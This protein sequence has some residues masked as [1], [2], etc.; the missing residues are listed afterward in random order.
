[1]FSTKNFLFQLFLMLVF[2]PTL[3]AADPPEPRMWDVKSAIAFALQ[4]N[5]DSQ[6]ATQR[7]AE[8]AAM[9]SKAQVAKYPQLALSSSY[10]WTNNPLYSFGNIV[11]QGAITPTTD[12][13][14]PGRNDNLKVTAD[15]SYRFYDGGRKGFYQQAAGYGIEASAQQRQA[16]LHQLGFEV[17]RSFERISETQSVYLARQSAL[18]ALNSSVAV[19]RARF[20]AGELLKIDLLN[21]EVQQ[22]QAEEN[23]IQAEQ[24]LELAKRIFAHLLGLKNQP[25]HIIATPELPP[26]PPHGF[27][28]KQRPERQSLSAA[29][30]AAEAQLEAAK[31]LRRPSVDGFGSY[32][33]DRGFKLDGGS[34]SWLA[35]A[36]IDFKLFD[37]YNSRAEIALEQA[38]LERLRAEEHKLEL[39]IDLE[40]SRAELALS[41]ARQR[42]LVTDKIVE[43]ARESVELSRARFREGV[44]LAS[45]LIDSETRLTEAEVRQAVA[46]SALRLAAAD[47]RRA[48]GFAL[49]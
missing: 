25:I 3:S 29:I 11:N 45:D 16:V 38:R 17:F 4:N 5:P 31:G 32:Q 10:T 39:A 46:R 14:D 22:S 37:G 47:L 1:M 19:A 7:L 15:L 28:P 27:E 42:L 44:I 34:H 43:Q 18:E 49:Y 13:N 36:R 2:C 6:I 12:F 33:I 40:V 26:A 23:L 9:L 35:G 41:Q 21:L 24:D 20:D 8:A 48:A 30:Q